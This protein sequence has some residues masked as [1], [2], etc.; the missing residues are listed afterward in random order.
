MLFRIAELISWISHRM[1]LDP[2]DVIAT[3]TPAGVAAMH[4]PPAWLTPGV[5]VHVEVEGFGRLS[6]PVLR[7]EPFLDH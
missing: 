4:Q 6:N 7:G 5:T 2:G 3:G 1:P